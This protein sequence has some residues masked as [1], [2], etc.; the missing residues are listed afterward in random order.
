MWLSTD[1]LL[2]EFGSRGARGKYQEFVAEGMGAESIW[3]EL[4]GQIYL[5][6][7][8]FVDQMRSKLG[9]RDEDVNIPKVQQ[10]GVA[11][12]LSAIR[13]QHKDR[14]DAMRAAYQT[15]AYSY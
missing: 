5:G 10:R 6:D 8:E 3:K 4:K 9:K 15:G 13:R 14:D 11:P 1:D 2:A 7:N 12:K